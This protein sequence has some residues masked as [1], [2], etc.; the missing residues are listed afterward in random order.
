MPRRESQ[1]KIIV[2]RCDVLDNPQKETEKEQSGRK[3]GSRQSCHKKPTKK[4]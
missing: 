2:S 4:E 1:D 3:R